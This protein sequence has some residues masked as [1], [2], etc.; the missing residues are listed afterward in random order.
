[1]INP[2]YEI[3]KKK[4]NEKLKYFKQ[5]DIVQRGLKMPDSVCILAPGINAI[6]EGAYEKI[7]APY[8]I[9]VNYG[10]AAPLKNRQPDVWL[11]TDCNCI[12]SSWFKPINDKYNG[13]R[14]FAATVCA[15]SVPN[16][17]PYE[18]NKFYSLQLYPEILGGGNVFHPSDDFPEYTPLEGV[19]RPDITCVGTAIRIAHLNGVKVIELCGVDMGNLY[20]DGGYRYP[21]SPERT[22]PDDCMKRL[23]SAIKWMKSQNI[24]VVTLSTTALEEPEKCF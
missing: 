15:C 17:Q 20:F 12:R 8:I 19:F 23:D 9:A 24:K 13:I 10:A 14:C 22:A 21:A 18:R 11:V 2:L 16:P 1:M 7:T 6:T 5:F 4:R 3:P